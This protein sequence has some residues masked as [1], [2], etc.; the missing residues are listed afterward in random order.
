MELEE[1]SMATAFGR[2]V[3]RGAKLVIVSPFFLLPGRHWTDDIP[4]LA[5]QSA[6]KHAGVKYLVAAPLGPHP[7]LIEVLWRRIAE[8][9]TDDAV[10]D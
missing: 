8:L 6:A 1:P 2:C 10:H 7:L 5:A 9:P 3:E 4:A